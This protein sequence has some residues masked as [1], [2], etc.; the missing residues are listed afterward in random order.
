MTEDRIYEALLEIKGD[1]AT[2]REDVAALKTK[3]ALRDVTCATHLEKITALDNWRQLHENQGRPPSKW[4]IIVT[5]LISQLL[6]GLGIWAS[7]MRAVG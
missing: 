4:A 6:I 7:V 3:D 5:T 1:T 2:I